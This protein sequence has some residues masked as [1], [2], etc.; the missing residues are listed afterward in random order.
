MSISDQAKTFV[1]TAEIFLKNEGI[2]LLSLKAAS[3]RA[4]DG[5]L[6][7]QYEKAEDIL[8]KSNLDIIEKI[9]LKGLEEQHV[10]FYCK[11]K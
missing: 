10:L 8:K 11:M 2:G 9:D 6:E 1:K 7:I 4:A 5:S 3:E